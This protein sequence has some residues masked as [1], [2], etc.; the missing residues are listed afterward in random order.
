MSVMKESVLLGWVFLHSL[1]NLDICHR[2]IPFIN[3]S[4]HRYIQPVIN[5][6][7]IFG[8]STMRET[9]C[10]MLGEQKLL[11]YDSGLQ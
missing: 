7:N 10:L 8:A 5:I 6:A 2:T 3:S 11:G 4:F 9:L 1:P